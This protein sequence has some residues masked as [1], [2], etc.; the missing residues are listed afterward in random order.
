EYPAG[1]AQATLV[2]NLGGVNVWFNLVKFERDGVRWDDDFKMAAD[3]G[4]ERAKGWSGIAVVVGGK[5]A[6]VGIDGEGAE[7]ASQPGQF[8]VDGLGMRMACGDQ[9]LQ[10]R[11]GTVQRVQKPVIGNV[12]RTGPGLE[13]AMAARAASH[14]S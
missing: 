14:I 6:R 3:V 4:V 12:E 8:H 5:L 13:T 7:G 11:K 2:A 1:A 9:V 10:G